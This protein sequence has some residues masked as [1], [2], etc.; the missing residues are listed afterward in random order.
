VRLDSCA[1]LHLDRAGRFG[2]YFWLGAVGWGLGLAL[3][4]AV[5]IARDVPAGVL[6]T[7][8]AAPSV[9]FLIGVKVSF[10]LFGY[11]RLVLYE[12]VAL[13][14]AVTAAALAALGLPVLPGLDLVALGMGMFLVF[15]RL[16]CLHVGCC[17]GRPA[18]WGIAYG[19]DHARTGFTRDYVGVRLFPVQLVESLA[20][21]AIT[22]AC[23]AAYLVG[24]PAPGV[25]LALYLIL[26]APVRFALELWRGDDDRPHILGV[27][28]AQLIAVASAWWAWWLW[29][30][31]AVLAVAGALATAAVLLAV[32]QRVGRGGALAVRQPARVRQL[33]RAVRDVTADPGDELAVSDTDDGLRLSCSRT[34][35]GYHLAVSHAAHSLTPRGARTVARYVRAVAGAESVDVDAGRTPGVFHLALHAGRKT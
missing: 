16:G 28:E 20:T 35:D 23:A 18:R 34:A 21:L 29:R 5:G 10:I 3:A 26:Y 25:V 13:A 1:R 15:G 4:L 2:S 24:D 33:T 8:A 27:S 7:V 11:E 12:L 17:H 19:D 30:V 32:A 9:S 14:L 22:G 6:V 31:P